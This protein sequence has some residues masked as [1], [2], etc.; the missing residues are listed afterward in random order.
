MRVWD[1]R[2]RRTVV[3]LV[4]TPR[5]WAWSFRRLTMRTGGVWLGLAVRVHAGP[6]GL[7]VRPRAS[8]G[9]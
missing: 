9:R 4:W 7:M 2:F 6:F 5:W 1:V 3:T 8:R